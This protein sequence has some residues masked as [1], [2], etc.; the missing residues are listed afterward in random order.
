[1]CSVDGYV[2][3]KLVPHIYRQEVY[4][5][6]NKIITDPD[7]QSSKEEPVYEPSEVNESPVNFFDPD[8]QLYPLFGEIER[9]Y[10]VLLHDGDCVFIPAFYFH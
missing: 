3:L 10:T 4:A 1:L 6:K 2:Q 9:R 8:Y 7:A 5:G